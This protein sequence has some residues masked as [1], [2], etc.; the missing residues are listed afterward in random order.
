MIPMTDIYLEDARV[1]ARICYAN[2]IRN[3][4]FIYES[5]KFHISVRFHMR[6]AYRRDDKIAVD[7]HAGVMREDVACGSHRSSIGV[8]D[9]SKIT[10]WSR[11]AA[12]WKAEKIA[13]KCAFAHWKIRS[14]GECL[15]LFVPSCHPWAIEFILIFFFNLSQIEL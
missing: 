3:C 6:L 12:E 2:M 14:C 5:H 13:E 15:A 10:R 4:S 7:H 11:I 1:R 8:W 9:R